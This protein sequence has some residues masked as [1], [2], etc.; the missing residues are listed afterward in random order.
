MSVTPYGNT[1][2]PTPDRDLTRCQTSLQPALTHSLFHAHLMSVPLELQH[3]VTS[4]LEFRDNV[5]HAFPHLQA[6][7]YHSLTPTHAHDPPSSQA[8][9]PPQAIPTARGEPSPSKSSAAS[10]H[11]TSGDGGRQQRPISST[12]GVTTTGGSGNSSSSSSTGGKSLSE[13]H[14]SSAVADS[15][16]STDKAGG[17]MGKSSSSSAGDHL[18]G[19]EEH[20]W[21]SVEP[22]LPLGSAEDEL[23]QLLDV[24]QRKGTRLRNELERAERLERDRMSQPQ[25]SSP[26]SDP[27]TSPRPH[28]AYRDYWP[29][30]LPGPIG[31]FHSRGD[32]LAPPPPPPPVGMAMEAEAW[33]A[34][35]RLRQDRQY[36]VGRVSWAEAEAAA[37]HQRL[38]DLHGQ[39]LALAGD[40]RRLEDQVR[41]LRLDPRLDPRVDS[42]VDFGNDL[43]LQF[44]KTNG[45]RRDGPASTGGIVH[46][47][48]GGVNTVH[49]VSDNTTTTTTT[50]NFTKPRRVPPAV[51]VSV[52]SGEGAEDSHGIGGAGRGRVIRSASSVRINS[53]RD[54]VLPRVLK[55]PIRDR[56]QRHSNKESSTASSHREN[57]GKDQNSGYKDFSPTSE[58]VNIKDSTFASPAGEMKKGSDR[59]VIERERRAGKADG[60]FS[61]PV[62]LLKGA[63][64]KVQPN[65]QR[66]SAILREKDVLELQRQLLTTVMETELEQR[67]RVDRKDVGITA[68]PLVCTTGTMTEGWA[69]DEVEA[70]THTVH[71]GPNIKYDVVVH[72]EESRRSEANNSVAPEAGGRKVPAA[73]EKPPRRSRETRSASTVGTLAAH[74]H[75]VA[76]QSGG[77]LCHRESSASEVSGGR[78]S[79]GRGAGPRS[80]PNLIQSGRATPTNTPRSSPAPSIN[81]RMCASRTS[82]QEGGR[83][84]PL[85]R[86]SSGANGRALVGRRD[87]T[88]TTQ[89]NAKGNGKS[90]PGVGGQH[91]GAGVVDSSSSSSTS[92]MSSSSSTSSTSSS[93]SPSTVAERRTNRPASF[94]RKLMH[95]ILQQF[96]VKV[97]QYSNRTL[98]AASTWYSDQNIVRKSSTVISL[99]GSSQQPSSLSSSLDFSSS[100]LTLSDLRSPSPPSPSTPAIPKKIF[101]ELD[102]Q[103]KSRN[104]YGDSK[105]AVQKRLSASDLYN[106]DFKDVTDPR[107]NT[108]NIPSAGSKRILKYGSKSETISSELTLSNLKVGSDSLSPSSSVASGSSFYDS[109]NTDAET[110]DDINKLMHVEVAFEWNPIPSQEIRYLPPAAHMWTPSHTLTPDKRLPPVTNTLCTN[111]PRWTPS[112]KAPTM[113]G[114]AVSFKGKKVNTTKGERV[115]SSESIDMDDTGQQWLADSLEDESQGFEAVGKMRSRLRAMNGAVRFKSVDRPSV[116]SMVQETSASSY[117][118]SLQGGKSMSSSPN[119][120]KSKLCESSIKGNSES[121]GLQLQRGR[122]RLSSSL[123]EGGSP[124]KHSDADLNSRVHQILARIAGSAP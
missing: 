30:S 28:P 106:Q 119:F 46:S 120:Q 113:L 70:A 16:F 8:S 112:S 48:M 51:T 111:S 34:V 103:Q 115:N 100:P 1:G 80:R 99:D 105:K 54:V 77:S 86:S 43:N 50:T 29:H 25:A 74:H 49:I 87:S 3:E 47:V 110:I 81:T 82:P 69:G 14:S 9:Q 117:L 12:G 5:L 40:K 71:P 27:L 118:E 52:A 15:G 104:V 26:A 92:I 68:C 58:N 45:V 23:W 93:S 42:R 39:L 59:V 79:I 108:S 61:M 6:R 91:K 18:S 122:P 65:K 38:L 95:E 31:N 102:G 107:V 53:D 32:I 33:A 121:E 36:L 37:S 83:A 2:D 67:E 89:V 17:S 24:I 64:L 57:S 101:V 114:H 35:D 85:G 20:R 21:T 76:H 72:Q 97:S 75:H 55:V 10:H 66:I 56:T 41:A 7:A 22:E 124:L 109:I 13:T 94:F 4:L 19:V 96:G 63:R 11:V 116:L 98:K 73:V 44:V 84:T 88:K 123:R 60:G 62:S 78:D 90:S